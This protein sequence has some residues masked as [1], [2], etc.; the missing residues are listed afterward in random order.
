M[1]PIHWYKVSTKLRAYYTK[2]TTTKGCMRAGHTCY[3]AV[4]LSSQQT[5]LSQHSWQNSYH[6]GR[7]TWKIASTFV[8]PILPTYPCQLWLPGHS[9]E[10]PVMSP[11]PSK[12]FLGPGALSGA[13]SGE[14]AGAV[15]WTGAL[16]GAGVILHIVSP[17]VSV[18][19]FAPHSWTSERW[20][21]R[22]KT[23]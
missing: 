23:W 3:C 16:S 7:Q 12:P 20:E 8:L 5:L 13:R 9:L 1:L 6:A 10:V 14:G 15:T 19:C 2:N 22:R 18:A 4:W 21:K 11:L 17:A